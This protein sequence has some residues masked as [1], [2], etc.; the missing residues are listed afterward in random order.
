VPR[1]CASAAVS[2]ER[3]I[4]RSARARIERGTT[5]EPGSR[6]QRGSHRVGQVTQRQ[7]GFLD[8]AGMMQHASRFALGLEHGLLERLHE[9]GG[10][11]DGRSRRI[12]HRHVLRRDRE[13]PGIGHLAHRRGGAAVH[14]TPSAVSALV[15]PCLSIRR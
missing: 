14:S 8:R 9:H 11:R 2:W 10:Q 13:S 1:G 7:A 12:P 5:P 4:P 6:M 15:S 3:I